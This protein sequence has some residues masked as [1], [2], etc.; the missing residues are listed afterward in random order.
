MDLIE[1]YVQAVR[2]WLPRASQQ[3]IAAELAEDLRCRKEDSEGALGRPLDEAETAALLAK[4]GNPLQVAGQYLQEKP[5]MDPALSMIYRFVVKVVLLWILL[6]L[7][8][9]VAVPSAFLSA[10]PLAS[11]ADALGSFAFSAL[12]ALGCITL[13]FILLGGKDSARTWD[14][15]KLPPLL[16]Q[17]PKPVPRSGSLAEV[18]FGLLFAA[19]WVEGFRRL[20]IAWSSHMGGVYAAGPLWTGL[21]AQLFWPVLALTFSG[22]AVGALCLAKPHLVK[23]RLI[24]GILAD[25]FSAGICLVAIQGRRPEIARA[26][27]ALRDL[28]HT[29]DLSAA[30]DGLVAAMLVVIAVA[31]AISGLTR[32]IRLALTGGSTP[33]RS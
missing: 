26:L 17:G 31:S 32:I 9:C 21:H 12:F 13:V 25:A 28:G 18:V 4:V 10:H 8:V 33:G 6:P 22:V 27:A 20:P 5:L 11:M 16:K 7:H 1:R 2:F 14:P 19:W 3:D 24:Y 23:F 15:M 30:V 29:R